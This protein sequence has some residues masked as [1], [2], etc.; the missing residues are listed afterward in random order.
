ML[1]PD[2]AS[3][4]VRVILARQ[5]RGRDATLL[6]VAT[7]VILLSFA[8]RV[9]DDQ[10]ISLFGLNQFPVPELCGSRAW[11]GIECPGCGLT[12]GFVRLAEGNWSAAVAHNRATPLMA[13]AVLAQIPYR[14]ALL[15][16]WNP[17]LRFA[18]A[19]W[20]NAFGWVLILTLIGNWL[21]E[22]FGV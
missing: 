10:R 8:L 14:L 7:V 12:R 20:P 21:L 22:M 16:K 11:F 19:P 2:D 6:F 15:M 17:A 1:E 3:V 13:F 4:P 5:R 18:Q 9:R